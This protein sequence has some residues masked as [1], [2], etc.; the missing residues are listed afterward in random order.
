[1]CVLM[2]FPAWKFPKRARGPTEP[3]TAHPHLHFRQKA[4]GGVANPTLGYLFDG[5]GTILEGKNFSF[6]PLNSGDMLG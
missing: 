5:P 3:I 4:L 2:F 1:M 6:F